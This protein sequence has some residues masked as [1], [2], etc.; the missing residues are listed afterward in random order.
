MLNGRATVL[1]ILKLLNRGEELVVKKTGSRG[2]V[3]KIFNFH[4]LSIRRQMPLFENYAHWM[5]IFAIIVKIFA[6]FFLLTRHSVACKLKT[7]K[8]CDIVDEHLS[9]GLNSIAKDSIIV[10]QCSTHKVKKMLKT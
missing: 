5:P 3:G 4:K 7:F 1:R 8:D 9:F 10:H 2:C 6:S